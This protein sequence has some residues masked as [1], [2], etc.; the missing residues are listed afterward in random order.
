MKPHVGIGERNSSHIPVCD[1]CEGYD[2]SLSY[3]SQCQATYCQQCWQVPITHRRTPKAGQLVHE[4]TNLALAKKIQNCI[5]P[6]RTAEMIEMLHKEDQSTTWF[7]VARDMTGDA[8]SVKFWNYQRFEQLIFKYPPR[9]RSR[10][11]PGLVSFLGQTG[12]GKSSLINLLITMKN[13]ADAPAEL[14]IV[15]STENGQQATSGDV[16]LY[17][18]PASSNSENPILYA[19]C[20]GLF[21]G[22]IEPFSHTVAACSVWSKMKRLAKDAIELKWIGNDKKKESRQYIVENFY[23]RLLYTFSDVVIFVLPANNARTVENIVELLLDWGKQSVQHSSNHPALPHAVIVLNMT[24]NDLPL[25]DWEIRNTTDWLLS[26]IDASLH[27]NPKFQNYIQEGDQQSRSFTTEKLLRSY[28]STVNAV[29]IPSLA[30]GLGRINLIERQVLI[31]FE[32]IQSCCNQTREKK[33]GKRMLLTADQFNPYL[34]LAFT[35][36]TSRD[37]LSTPFDFVKASF[38]ARPIS[39]DFADSI[40]VL[41]CMLM[42]RTKG[43]PGLSAPAIFNSLSTVVS[44]CIMLDAARNRRLGDC[45]AIFSNYAGF[46]TKALQT[47][48]NQH[49][50]CAFPNCINKRAF[51]DVGH[52]DVSGRVLGGRRNPDNPDNEPYQSSF[53]EEEVLKNFLS[54][55]TK[56]LSQRLLGL[57]RPESGFSEEENAASEHR[58]TIRKF[59]QNHGGQQGASYFKDHLTCLSCLM[60]IAEHILPCG[61]V[62]CTRCVE[63]IAQRIEPEET[64]VQLWECPMERGYGLNHQIALKPANAGLRTLSLDGGGVRGI[65]E[66]VTLQ[67]LEKTLGGNI[68]VQLFFDLIVGTSVGGVIAAGLGVQGWRVSEC[69]ERFKSLC[70]RAFQWTLLGNLSRFEWLSWVAAWAAR[71]KTTDLEKALCEAFGNCDHLFGGK[72]SDDHVHKPKVAFTTTSSGGNPYLLANYNRIEKPNPEPP[73]DATTAAAREDECYTFLRSRSP[74]HELYVWEALRASTAAPTWF[75]PFIISKDRNLPNRSFIDGG[76]RYNN[77]IAVAEQEAQLLWPGHLTDLALSVGTGFDPGVNDFSDEPPDS[78]QIRQLMKIVLNS[79]NAS[80]DSDR[81]WREYERKHQAKKDKLFRLDVVLEKPVPE[82][83]E[84]AQINSLEEATRVF[85]SKRDNMQLLELIAQRLIASCFY[86]AKDETDKTGDETVKG[87]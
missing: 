23:S 12:S 15:G 25:E 65:V 32:H 69:T 86:F 49:W 82:L 4:K 80:M 75:K 35:H 57:S 26:G 78:L 38:N 20:E 68:P 79:V 3:C 13:V 87:L 67:Q 48:S 51:H 50:P 81:T 8:P 30:E 21:G 40:V 71:F 44:S 27:N 84:V 64:I 55:I 70:N 9:R 45:G 36:F 52:Q 22:E 61:H 53:V 31:L 10:L 54:A 41:T 24:N 7:G 42:A 16:H 74:E 34:Q 77:P 72:R 6:L 14:P 2:D 63:T 37:G 5:Q 43:L 73:A 62:I 18:D 56:D 29:R 66:L 58:Q 83:Y 28:Y 59:Y 19:D 46:C 60:G 33:R 11:Y 39:R 17:P 76:I 47:V 85:W 1:D